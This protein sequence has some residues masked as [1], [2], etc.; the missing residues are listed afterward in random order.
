VLFFAEDALCGSSKSVAWIALWRNV[1]AIVGLSGSEFE[2]G[3]SND[4]TVSCGGDNLFGDHLELIDLED[5]LDLGKEAGQQAKVSATHSDQRGDNVWSVAFQNMWL[6]S[7][8]II[9]H[10]TGIRICR[11]M[12]ARA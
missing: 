11:V 9:W 8:L 1:W 12:R 2:S 10:T 6:T 5:A 3:L 4:E 7:V